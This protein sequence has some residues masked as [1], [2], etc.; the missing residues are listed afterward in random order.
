MSL[1]K[2]AETVSKDPGSPVMLV[3]SAAIGRPP[4]PGFG[5]DSLTDIELEIADLVAQGLSNRQIAARIYRSRFTVDYHLRHIF[6]RLGISGR[7][8]LTRIVFERELAA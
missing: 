1:K 3:R 8:Q 6:Q 5:W 4:R 2:G 7:V